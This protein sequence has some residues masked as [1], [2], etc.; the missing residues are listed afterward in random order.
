VVGCNQRDH[1]LPAGRGLVAEDLRE[2]MAERQGR[3]MAHDEGLIEKL[4]ARDLVELLGTSPGVATKLR[5]PVRRSLPQQ[6]S[7]ERGGPTPGSRAERRGELGRAEPAVQ[8][9]N[10]EGLQ[11]LECSRWYG[12]LPLH[13]AQAHGLTS[14]EYRREH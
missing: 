2:Q 9:E 3:R 10:S 13:L 1:E 7:C 5:K 6:G 11:C 12:N 8:P 4:A 14:A